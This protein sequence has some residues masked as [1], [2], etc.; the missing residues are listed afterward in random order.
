MMGKTQGRGTAS[1]NVLIKKKGGKGD[2]LVA[3]AWGKTEELPSKKW[4]P[5]RSCMER[6]HE[7]S[8]SEGGE[9]KKTPTIRRCPSPLGRVSAYS[10]V[11]G[12][13]QPENGGIA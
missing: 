4:G 5:I 2:G 3:R 8:I 9:G 7:L 12:V 10:P 13:I 6:T 11:T 1:G